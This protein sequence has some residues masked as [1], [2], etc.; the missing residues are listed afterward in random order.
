[1]ESLL[2][3]VEE[4]DSYVEG[5]P[6][7]D[8]FVY[9]A[10][11][12]LLAGM[13]STAFLWDQWLNRSSAFLDTLEKFNQDA[14]GRLFLWGEGAIPCFL[15]KGWAQDQMWASREM[16]QLAFMT[17]QAICKFNSMKRLHIKPEEKAATPVHLKNGLASPYESLE[18][19]LI[20][21]FQS[22]NP[23]SEPTYVGESYC[24]ES[25]IALIVKRRLRQNLANI[26]YDITYVSLE[27]YRPEKR[28][29]LWKWNNNDG[30]IESKFPDQPASWKKLREQVAEPDESLLPTLAEEYP[31]ILLLYIVVAPHRLNPAVVTLLED[32]DW[33]RGKWILE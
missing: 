23:E 19:V 18:K 22:T 25:L 10:R 7:S 28:R 12:T 33:T 3:E 31:H 17:M 27:T 16:E 2:K 24:L 13:L 11:I 14:K 8:V 15:A 21:Q 30:L 4:R 20:K 1:M 6:L 26:W 9:E 29:D 32:I 5:S